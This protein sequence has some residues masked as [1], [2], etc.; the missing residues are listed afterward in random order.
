MNNEKKFII[1]DVFTKIL[2]KFTK[3]NNYIFLNNIISM[4]IMLNDKYIG[5]LFNVDKIEIF[6]YEIIFYSYNKINFCYKN[7]FGVKNMSICNDT[8]YINTK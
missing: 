4:D 5:T 7:I 3:N 8:I 2:C 6:K 1:D